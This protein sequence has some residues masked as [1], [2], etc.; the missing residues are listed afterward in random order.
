MESPDYFLHFYAASIGFQKAAKLQHH[1]MIIGQVWFLKGKK[2]I[3]LKLQ[4]FREIYVISK[5]GKV[6]LDI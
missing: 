2:K 5:E 6:H 1:K 4:A 3:S